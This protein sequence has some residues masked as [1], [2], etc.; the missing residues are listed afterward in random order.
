MNQKM[1]AFDGM[2]KAGFLHFQASFQGKNELVALRD[3]LESSERYIDFELSEVVTMIR[4]IVS[5]D[6]G[7]I[8]RFGREYGP[9]MYVQCIYGYEGMGIPDVI[10]RR[11]MRNVQADEIDLVTVNNS[12]MVR[13]WWDA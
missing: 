4:N 11:I 9:V 8:I 3:Y 5:C 7:L 1:Q 12:T 10:Y 6:P 13:I 2:R